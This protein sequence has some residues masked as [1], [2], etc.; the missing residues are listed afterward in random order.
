MKCPNCG[1][2]A[3]FVNGK[4][5]CLDCG[6][7]I[8]PEQ[9]A[10]QNMAAEQIQEV[11]TP[12]SSV[13]P[14]IQPISDEAI[15]SPQTESSDASVA[16]E[17]QVSSTVPLEVPVTTEK[18]VQQYYE[19]ALAENED[20]PTTGSHAG[21]YDF[22]ENQSTPTPET[23]SIADLGA[24][25]EPSVSEMASVPVPTAEQIVTAE[26]EP[27][28]TNASPSE[29]TLTIANEPE[30]LPIANETE[31]ET[32]FSPNSFDIKENQNNPVEAAPVVVDDAATAEPAVEALPEL[33]PTL[34]ETFAEPLPEEIS[35]PNTDQIPEHLGEGNPA[36]PEPVS[37]T[38]DDMLGNEPIGEVETPETVSPIS[39]FGPTPIASE[40]NLTNVTSENPMPS[41]ES[42]FGTTGQESAPAP[43]DSKMPTAQD[44]GVAPKPEPK[45]KNKLVP[46]IIAAVAGVLLLGGGAFAIITLTGEKEVSYPV[47][48]SDEGIT[49]L[50]SAVS[51]AIQQPQGIA[52][53][54]NF[55]ANLSKL[56]VKDTAVDKV[57]A[58]KQVGSN[59]EL[60]G[61]WYTDPDEDIMVDFDL[62]DLNDKR[63]YI[64]QE[65]KTYIYNSET[66]KYDAQN[67][68]LVAGVPAFAGVEEKTALLYTTNIKGASLLGKEQIDGSEYSK[69]QITPDGEIIEETLAVMGGIFK[70]ADYTTIN[71]DALTLYVWI[72]SDNKI[73]KTSLSGEIE[74]DTASVSGTININGEATYQYLEVSIENPET[75]TE[76]K[77]N[78]ETSVSE[79]VTENEEEVETSSIDNGTKE[80][81][82]VEA[83]G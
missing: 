37:S 78:T 67:G 60:S 22:S 17:S 75:V 80:S 5:V 71:T 38:L 79:V 53:D 61:S 9:Q 28:V 63:T 59:Y 47:I 52:V 57:A 4:Y 20:Q 69:Y 64:S 1:K 55:E 49:N 14:S 2:E 56:T 65:E 54:Y 68:L 30:S 45:K 12:E 40:P 25:T 70:D 35:G 8:S 26:P 81:Q 41:V 74:I 32:Y 58:E 36:T 48:L 24:P 15:P 51:T 50:S 23:A 33:S 18:P 27:T 39:A 83:K 62:T 77:K 16:V 43:Q 34:P 6:I 21:V 10:A 72:S 31:P 13:T 7:E 73:K 66:Q 29:P 46:I 11:R 82:I 3:I 44:F 76:A 42:V 19:N